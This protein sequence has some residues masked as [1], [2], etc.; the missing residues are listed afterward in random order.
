MDTSSME[1]VKLRTGSS[2]GQRPFWQGERAIQWAVAIVVCF[3]VLA[4]VVP[5]LVQAV[6][7]RALYLDDIQPTFGNFARLMEDTEFLRSVLNSMIFAAI[8]TTFSCVVGAVAAILIGRTDMP[9]KGL[10]SGLMIWPIFISHLVITT[11]WSIVYGPAGYVTMTFKLAFGDVPWNLY[12]IVGMSVVAGVCQVPITYL[13]CLTALRSSDPTLE[14]AARAAGMRPL[15]VFWRITVPLL[16]P[17]L[18]MSS[19]LNL[20]MLLEAVSIPLVFGRPADIEMFMSYIYTRAISVSSP[21]YGLVAA[22][23][24]FLVLLVVVL[25]SSQRVLLRKPERFVTIAGKATRPRT[26]RLGN[27]RFVALA[28]LLL[29]LA[30]LVVLPLAGLVTYAF[31]SFLTPLIPI[32]EVLTL[33]NFRLVL[34]TPVY[35][36]SM[37]NSIIIGVVGGAFA[38]A[39][40]ALLAVVVHRSTFPF[41]RFLDI[42]SLLPR[43]VPGM[44]AGIGIFY[45]TVIVQPLGWLRETIFLLMIAFTMRYIPLGYGAMA[46]AIIKIDKQLDKSGRAIGASWWTTIRRIVLPLM[47]PAM[48][49]SYAILFI[50]FFKDYAT[51]VFL[52][53]PGSEV[54]GTT[55]L[56]MFL[57]G[58][59]GPASALATIQL[60]ITALFILGMRRIAG[61]SLYG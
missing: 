36:R 60:A 14:D 9:M 10:V 13:Y 55:L 53:A 56:Q 8:G 15:T 25:V 17:A 6:A 37:T 22:A 35:V 39:I 29:Y 28:A 19:I 41:R 52:V 3:L 12:S 40:V 47:V 1:S 16:R 4:P 45:V 48:L 44:I 32:R 61:V 26:M 46:T 38:V 20:V 18:I 34:S 7:D 23:A 5:L 50:H 31:S 59:T 54:L 57:S 33:D 49:S 2:P 30:I 27:W 21:D 42:I 24:C 58:E 43:A 51:G 11:G